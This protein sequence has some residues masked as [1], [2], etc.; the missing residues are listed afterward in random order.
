MDSL[1]SSLSMAESIEA[2]PLSQIL[3]QTA[4]IVERMHIGYTLTDLAIGEYLQNNI[5]Y[6]KYFQIKFIL[7]I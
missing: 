6:I 4:V 7:K 3:F 2:E 1:D 5:F